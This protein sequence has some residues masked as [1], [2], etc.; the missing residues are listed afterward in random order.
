MGFLAQLLAEL[1]GWFGL[2]Q[3]V[4]D[5]EK[6]NKKR[7]IVLLVLFLIMSVGILIY[8][9]YGVIQFFKAY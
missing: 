9:I 7:A 8:I 1:F 3:A 4:K 6:G 2:G 5:I